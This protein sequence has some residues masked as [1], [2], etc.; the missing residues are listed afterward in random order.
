MYHQKNGSRCEVGLS[1]LQFFRYARIKATILGKEP[2][3]LHHIFGKGNLASEC[4]SNYILIAKSLHVW[5]HSG[6]P[7]ELMALCVAAKFQ[8]WIRNGDRKEFD[9][10]ALAAIVGAPM[11]EWFEVRRDTAASNA[12]RELWEEVLEGRW[13]DGCL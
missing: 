12:E 7:R 1:A 3:E 2:V 9:T 4:E 10:E 8:K 5:G 11:R 6:H 13:P